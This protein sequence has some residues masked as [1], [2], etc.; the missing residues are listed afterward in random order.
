[1]A[2]PPHVV[3]DEIFDKY[4]GG[5]R[6]AIVAH[7]ERRDIPSFF[8]ATVPTNYSWLHEHLLNEAGLLSLVFSRSYM[9]DR[10]SSSGREVSS[11]IRQIFRDL[12][13]AELVTVRYTT[14]AF[15]GRPQ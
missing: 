11:R 15:I 3:L 9:P 1:M 5:K 4:G 12:A 6:A 10:N 2:D 7:E 8:G 14:V 13:V